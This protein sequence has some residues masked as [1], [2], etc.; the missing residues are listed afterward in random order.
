MASY[1]DWTDYDQAL[2]LGSDSSY[3][4]PRTA[5]TV[6]SDLLSQGQAVSSGD[7]G[8]WGGF[9]QGLTKTVLTY[10]LTKDAIQTQAQTATQSAAQL[11]AARLQASQLPLY[12]NNG[13]GLQ[14]SP[15]LLIGIGLVV[16]LMMKK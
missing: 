15:V 16:V 12:S 8:N 13:A 14:I 4:T 2:F 10:G 1:D 6:T 11:Q 7:S 9:F 3:N 5:S